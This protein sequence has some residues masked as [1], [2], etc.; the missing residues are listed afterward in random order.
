LRLHAG[1][2]GR[3]QMQD[4]LNAPNRASPRGLLHFP[5]ADAREW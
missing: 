3:A 4:V 2:I 5:E 1:L